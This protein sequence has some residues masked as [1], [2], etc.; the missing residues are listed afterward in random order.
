MTLQRHA[1]GRAVIYGRERDRK[2]SIPRA[3]GHRAAEGEALSLEERPL[4]SREERFRSPSSPQTPG[5][6]RAVFAY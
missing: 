1:G 6:P 2:K 5:E 3:A 4:W